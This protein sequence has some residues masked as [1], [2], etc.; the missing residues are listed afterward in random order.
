MVTFESKITKKGNLKVSRQLRDLLGLKEGE[1]VTVTL[2]GL[3]PDMLD[4]LK[5]PTDILAE[6][7]IPE[8][9]PLEVYVDGGRVVI[10]EA[11]DG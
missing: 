1:K 5:I 10:Q 4:E 7:G 11:I 2:D 6:A 8:D 9:R 3:A